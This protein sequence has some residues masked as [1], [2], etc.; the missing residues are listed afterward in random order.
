MSLTV[1]PNQQPYLLN[2]H[3][4]ACMSDIHLHLTS[5]HICFSNIQPFVLS[6]ELATDKYCCNGCYNCTRP[7]P[8]SSQYGKEHLQH[9]DTC[10]LLRGCFCVDTLHSASTSS[11]FLRKFLPSIKYNVSTKVCTLI[12][13]VQVYPG[14]YHLIFLKNCFHK[15]GTFIRII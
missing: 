7:V 9:A 15:V 8:T 4:Q 12:K 3:Q 14:I 13:H 10:T 2:L 1:T 5:I 11:F 6:V